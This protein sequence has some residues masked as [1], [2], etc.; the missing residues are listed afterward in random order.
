MVQKSYQ[1]AQN[2][3]D[4]YV[5]NKNL[6][7]HCYAV[8]SSMEAYAKKFANEGKIKP[9]EIENWKIAG[10][11]HDFDYEKF[12]EQHPKKGSETLKMEGWP[13]EI[14]HAV[15]SHSNYTGVPRQN[16]M[17]KTLYAVDE[18]AGFII[19][20]ALVRPDRLDTLEAKSVIKKLKDED[21]AEKINREEIRKGT[22]DLGVPLEEHINF[23][24]DAIRGDKRIT[25]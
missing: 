11:L 5:K 22:E 1:D 23:V 13:E 6:K 8:E 16:L 25:F 20:C 9:E 7:R 24:I 14:V 4:K 17:E 2:L 12:T 10:L 3:L 21:F 18:L 15:L 19:A